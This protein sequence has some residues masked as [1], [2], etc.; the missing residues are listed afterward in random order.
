MKAL[1]GTFNQENALVGAF[2][3]IFKIDGSFAA[4][5]RMLLVGML[6]S[7]YHCILCRIIRSTA[8]CPATI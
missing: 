3:V 2:S 8:R 1:L 4:L 6:E 5:V 7:H